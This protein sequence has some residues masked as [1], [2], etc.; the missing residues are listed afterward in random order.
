M[1]KEKKSLLLV[2]NILKIEKQA[3]ER[4]LVPPFDTDDLLETFSLVKDRVVDHLQGKGCPVTQ[5]RAAHKAIGEIIKVSR[6]PSLLMCEGLASKEMDCDLLCGIYLTIARELDLSLYGVFMPSHAILA[7]GTPRAIFYFDTLGCGFATKTEI[8]AGSTSS[9]R[10]QIQGEIYLRPL[11]DREFMST[12]YNTLGV[13]CSEIK[14]HGEAIFFFDKALECYP[15]DPRLHYHK[16]IALAKQGHCEQALEYG[17]RAISLGEFDWKAHLNMGAC[18]A[19]FEEYEQAL[20]FYNRAAELRPE[21]YRVYYYRADALMRYE[22]PD[23]AIKDYEQAI[24]LCP[25]DADLVEDYET[26]LCCVK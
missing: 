3:A 25:D 10:L 24:N 9:R 16:A 11:S 17:E 14:R 19:M 8:L 1:E 7:W 23:L 15:L 6:D 4:G 22:Q 12:Y 20:C 2:E 13:R 26:A 5:L 18:L 21:E